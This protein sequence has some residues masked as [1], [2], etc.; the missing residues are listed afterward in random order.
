DC[1]VPLDGLRRGL[2]ARLPEDIRVL[3]AREV[4]EG[5]HARSDASGKEYR[6]RLL[7]AEVVSP[8]VAPFVSPVRG[9]LDLAAMQEATRALEWRHDFTSFAPAGFTLE[10]RSR[11]VTLSRID[12]AGDELVYTVR[13]EGFLRHM[14]RTMVGT[15]VEAGRGRI[16]PSGVGAILEAR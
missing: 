15:I 8:F 3:E 10:N 13:G 12:E 9:P 14:V 11:T 16:P 7:R 4:G 2:N 6:Y 5:F 1:G